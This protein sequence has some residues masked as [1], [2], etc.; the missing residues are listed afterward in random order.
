MLF[1]EVLQ[2]HMY[3]ISTTEIESLSTRYNIYIFFS[4]TFIY[5]YIFLW[6]FFFRSIL[7]APSWQNGEVFSSQRSHRGCQIPVA[8]RCG[9]VMPW[10]TT[11]MDRALVSWYFQLPG[12]YSRLFGAKNG[13]Q[14]NQRGFFS[15][16]TGMLGY[17]I[18]I[19]MS[20]F[21]KGL[22]NVFWK[23]L[24][25]VFL[26]LYWIEEEWQTLWHSS[27]IQYAPNK[28][29][30]NRYC[31]W[32]HLT[33]FSVFP[34]DGFFFTL[35][36]TITYPTDPRKIQALWSRWFSELPIWWDMFPH[37]LE[38]PEGMIY[39]H[40]PQWRCG[41]SPRKLHWIHW[42]FELDYFSATTWSRKIIDIS[43]MLWRVELT[44]KNGIQKRHVINTYTFP[45]CYSCCCQR[46]TFWCFFWG[47]DPLGSLE[48]LHL[49]PGCFLVPPAKGYGEGMAVSGPVSGWFQTVSRDEAAWD[50]LGWWD[51]FVWQVHIG[52]L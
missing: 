4:Y 16:K 47:G 19:W 11:N 13:I 15:K 33:L 3:S 36:G 22:T 18:Y 34:G 38:G 5:I 28:D 44:Q 21:G 41:E 29:E 2:P 1:D 6:M 43:T 12:N 49:H 8:A 25:L 52:K 30:R 31:M 9:K 17:I 37:F 42:F 32:R 48:F 39:M 35:L 27:S 50:F 46:S 20:F 10:W 26:G 24:W 14:T 23:R 7:D 45:I 40:S 51:D